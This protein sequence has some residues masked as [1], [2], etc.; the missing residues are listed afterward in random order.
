M[1]AQSDQRTQYMI[2]A[3]KELLEPSLTSPRQLIA[4]L[5]ADYSSWPLPIRDGGQTTWKLHSPAA[6]RVWQAELIICRARPI[7]SFLQGTWG[8]GRL[9]SRSQ[10]KPCCPW[11]SVLPLCLAGKVLYS[12]AIAE[13]SLPY[14]ST[15]EPA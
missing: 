8:A 9:E 15:E 3:L 6:L 13:Y 7:A 4:A 5:T 10:T 1:V 2:Q 12:L 11:R 14:Q